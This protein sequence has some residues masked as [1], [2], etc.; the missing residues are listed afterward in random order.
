MKLE[1]A[2]LR[3]VYLVLEI[4]YIYI[5]IYILVDSQIGFLGLVRQRAKKK[6]NWIQTNFTPLK[7]ALSAKVAKGKIPSMSVLYMTLN[8]LI[9]FQ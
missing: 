1:L 9:R 5:Y 3:M 4:V 7:M 6:K 8:N 2:V